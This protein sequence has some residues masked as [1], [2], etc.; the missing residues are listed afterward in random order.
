MHY[1]GDRDARTI[2]NFLSVNLSNDHENNS[3]VTLTE[4]YK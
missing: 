2:G 3:P 1:R 4:Q